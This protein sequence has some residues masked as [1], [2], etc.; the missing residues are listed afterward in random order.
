V[1]R[2]SI[3]M[4]DI[5]WGYGFPIGGVA[6]MDAREGVVSPGGVGFDIDCGVRLVRTGLEAGAVKPHAADLL[7]EVM[8][9]IPT[10]TGHAGALRLNERELKR[11][12][13]RGVPFLA[14]RGLA[15]EDDIAHTE[16][17][18]AVA[19]A[20][21]DAV[22]RKALK[23]GALQVGSLGGGN[24]F[25]ELQE[26]AEVVDDEVAAA[27]G[28]FPGQAVVMIHSGS[29]GFGHQICT[30]HLP[31]MAAA[32]ARYGIVL[33]D[34]QL[35]CAPLHAPEALD[36]LAAMACACNF[37]FCNRQVMMH[38]L[39]LAFEQVLANRGRDSASSWSTTW[40]TT[41]RSSRSTRSRE[42]RC[43]SWCTARGRRA[44]SGPAGR[45]FTGSTARPASR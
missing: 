7:H 1:V 10:G 9:R 21:A 23:R 43:T 34:R 41:S 22:S 45:S 32:A 15:T 30:D 13:E 44:P 18:G 31:R 19:D 33:P 8:R 39:R 35:A 4:P 28:L 36:Y 27:F 38:E 17:G 3:A 16:E 42:S 25:V 5:H 40:P 29:R 37:A 11:L 6:A 14:E 26:V 24:H 12:I 2:A 20:H